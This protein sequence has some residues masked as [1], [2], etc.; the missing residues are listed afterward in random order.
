MFWNINRELTNYETEI[1]YSNVTKSTNSLDLLRACKPEGLFGR[2]YEPARV[3]R[4]PYRANI[5]IQYVN[6]HMTKSLTTFLRGLFVRLVLGHFLN[7][8]T[9]HQ[10]QRGWFSTSFPSILG[11]LKSRSR[12]NRFKANARTK[13]SLHVRLRIGPRRH[14]VRGFVTCPVRCRPRES[15][16]INI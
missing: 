14:V 4:H 10:L 7:R 5:L 13:T 11:T 16:G 6:G 1:R 2:S 15:G 3:F 9:G 12:I 8:K